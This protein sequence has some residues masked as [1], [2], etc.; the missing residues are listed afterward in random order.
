MHL[1]FSQ[2]GNSS[3]TE[4]THPGFKG[5]ARFQIFKLNFSWNMSKMHYFSDKFSK[6]A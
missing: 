2:K 3:A 1:S 5:V 6:I 4:E